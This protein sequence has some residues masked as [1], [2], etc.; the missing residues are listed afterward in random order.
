MVHSTGKQISPA[1]YGA[2][3]GDEKNRFWSL[4]VNG[5]DM[6][7]SFR[8]A[9]K[10]NTLGLPVGM[11]DFGSMGYA[12]G[13]VPIVPGTGPPTS[14]TH[15]LGKRIINIQPRVG[16]FDGWV[17]VKAGEPG[18]WEPYGLIGETKKP[19]KVDEDKPNPETPACHD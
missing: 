1:R 18:T 16:S 8:L 9:E 10:G 19:P 12:I 7:R 13:S 11:L 15:P 17:C 14:G 3:T 6:H 2:W 4:R 5:S